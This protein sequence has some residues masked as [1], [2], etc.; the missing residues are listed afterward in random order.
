MKPT[1]LDYIKEFLRIPRYSG[2]TTDDI[3]N[4]GCYHC[5]K[6]YDIGYSEH[7]CKYKEYVGIDNSYSDVGGC[8]GF[9]TIG[10]N[11]MYKFNDNPRSKG[12]SNASA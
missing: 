4:L 7:Y 10:N 2:C 5:E 9:R 11:V 1:L 3:L 6:C 8:R 12:N